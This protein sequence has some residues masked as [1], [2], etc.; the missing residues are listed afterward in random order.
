M[1]APAIWLASFALAGILPGALMF[2]AAR[3]RI[4]WIGVLGM[5][6]ALVTVAAGLSVDPT[7]L[8]V[9]AAIPANVWAATRPA[10]R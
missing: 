6:L 4:D 9:L 5:T 10:I 8:G 2:Y 1:S 3:N 7:N